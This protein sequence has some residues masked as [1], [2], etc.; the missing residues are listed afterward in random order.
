MQVF[1]EALDLSCT[2]LPR[3]A[4]P[5]GVQC[6]A[7]R[8]DAGLRRFT[9]HRKALEHRVWPSGARVAESSIFHGVRVAHNR[10]PG[11]SPLRE[12]ATLVGVLAKVL[13]TFANTTN[14]KI[15]RVLVVVLAVLAAANTANTANTR[16]NTANTR[17]PVVLVHGRPAC[18]TPGRDAECVPRQPPPA[19]PMPTR[20]R[21]GADPR[22]AV[23][24]SAAGGASALTCCVSCSTGPIAHQRPIAARARC[25]V[26]RP[27][28]EPVPCEALARGP[29]SARLQHIER[30]GARTAQ[31]RRQRGQG[32]RAR[33]RCTTVVP[34]AWYGS[35][36]RQAT[37]RAK[38][39]QL[40]PAADVTTR[41]MPVMKVG[42]AWRSGTQTLKGRE[43]MVR[44]AGRGARFEKCV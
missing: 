37:V 12:R 25:A 44:A 15:G 3:H 8:H 42:P 23:V 36:A 6:S 5:V 30:G 7:P 16:A 4:L 34:Y 38:A 20:H 43:C 21:P 14:T 19:A 41:H 9:L 24:Y 33:A 40:T 22:P 26:A 17:E 31:V 13:P 39:A 11:T 2:A 1:R 28:P 32:Q 29:L 27:L 18:A 10:V 35:R